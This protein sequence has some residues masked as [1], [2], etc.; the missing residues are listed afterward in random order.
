MSNQENKNLD[1]NYTE[2]VTFL[3]IYAAHA[4]VEFTDDERQHITAYAGPAVFEKMEAIFNDNTDIE[5]LQ[6]IQSFKGVYYPTVAQKD[7]LIA[8]MIVLFEADGDH[9]HLEK[10]LTT[11]LKHLL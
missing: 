11:F 8:R 6:I 5:V 2:F 9:S 3:L 4:D 10:N 1:W 7:E